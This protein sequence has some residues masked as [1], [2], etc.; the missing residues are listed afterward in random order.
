MD[1]FDIK[2]I[3]S[4]IKSVLIRLICVICVLL[5]WEKI[6]ERKFIILLIFPLFLGARCGEEPP[7]PQPPKPTHKTKLSIVWHIPF[8]SDS[9]DYYFIDPMLVQD[10]LILPNMFGRNSDHKPGV[11]VF[12]KQT[13]KRHSAWLAEPGGI[14]DNND[15]LED[16]KLGGTNDNIIFI[17]SGSSLYAFDLNSKQRLWKSARPQ[18]WDGWSRFSMVAENPFLVYDLG[19]SKTKFV[20]FDTQSGA[21]KDILELLSENGYWVSVRPPGWHIMGNGDTLLF[22][23]TSEWNF[24]IG[25]GKIRAFC[26]NLTQKKMVWEKRD[27]CD[28][29]DGGLYPSIVTDEQNAIICGMRSI[30]C[31]NIATG[32]LLWQHDM[33]KNG[34]LIDAF[35]D[36]PPLYN[37]GKVYLRGGTGNLYCYDAVTGAEL[38]VNKLGAI[39]AP[40]GRMDI[41][42]GYLYFTGWRGTGAIGLYCVSASTGQMKWFDTGPNGRIS[43]GVIADQKTG[44]LYCH[45]GI[46][47]MCVDLRKTPVN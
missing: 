23:G 42:D 40:H 34:Y 11:G 18:G 44:Y 36:T 28:D 22:F 24:N 37:E 21:K 20:K 13:G 7:P 12:H 47:V 15:M 2:L 8:H 17:N 10:Y 3:I 38:W 31:F 19:Y 4:S 46:F 33:F 29:T 32:E 39:P 6:K 16:C 14:L 27:F 5:E 26:Y 1:R 35:S 9:I 45:S 25:R 43:F 30:H 41:Y